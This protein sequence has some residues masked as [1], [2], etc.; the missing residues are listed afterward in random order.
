[1]VVLMVSQSEF[2]SEGFPA[3]QTQVGPLTGVNPSMSDDV[4]ALSK[5]FP[6]VRARE[7]PVPGV[8]LLVVEEN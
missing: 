1:M 8:D 5:A 6:A 3:L 7:R 4:R 2:L